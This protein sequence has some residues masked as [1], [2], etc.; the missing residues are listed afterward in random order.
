MKSIR[1]KLLVYIMLLVSTPIVIT[2]AMNIITMQKNYETELA[3]NNM[4][5]ASSIADQVSA[6]ITEA[7]SMTEQVA[8]N[9]IIN[10]TPEEQN[11]ILMNIYRKHPYFEQLYVQDIE[12][13]QTAM[14][15]GD[16][17]DV[18][19]RW[20]FIKAKEE[21]A[22]FVSKSY[23]D[24]I[25]NAPVAT[26]AIPIYD[27]DKALGVMAVDIKLDELQKRVQK[28]NEGSRYAF[29]IDGDGVV[30]A[31]PDSMQISELYNYKTLKKTLLKRD[32]KGAVIADE[33]RNHVTEE[34]DIEV[35]DELKQII[36]K[37][38]NGEEGSASYKDSKGVNVVSAY[39]SISLPGNSDNW[40]V[41]TV[42]NKVDAMAFI[43]NIFD[44]NAIIGLISIF[45]SAIF[46]RI[47]AGR[48]AD[49]IIKAAEY[50]KVIAQGNFVIDVDSKL[51]SR[52]DEIGIMTTGIQLMKESLKALTMKVSDEAVNIQ[53]KVELVLGEINELNTN[54]EGISATTEQ[55]SA[56]SEE[57]AAS[58][59]E[60]T[61]TT[62]EIERAA[63]TIAESSGKGALAA[64]DISERAEITKEKVN[65]S[66]QKTIDIF[67]ESKRHLENAIEESKVVEEINVLS[68]SIMGIAEQTNLLAINAAIEAARAGESGK[69]FAVV[70]NEITKLADQAK[71]TVKKITEVTSTVI[72]AVDN[73]SSNA[74]NLLSFVSKD[75]EDDYK[76]MLEIAEKYREDAKYVEDLVIEFSA[77]SEELLAS[78][79]NMAHSIEGVAI[80]ANESATG[81]A[82]IAASVS[83][84]NIKS[85]N[86]KD[87]IKETK[88]S[89]YNLK[90]EIAKFKF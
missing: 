75:V 63:Q 74:N 1:Q 48:I 52:K 29:V 83:E 40:A 22:S 4:M 7:Y 10:Y 85:S 20:W 49:P 32:E 87:E 33:N 88:E 70:A 80:S 77:T 73:L 67:T 26:I 90:A 28:Y 34:Q 53:N 81:T 66:I 68:A 24:L 58:T 55:L 72:G 84:A 30:I 60:M 39:K 86:V 82:E 46:I 2:T 12:G 11:E 76:D 57:T 71:A 42:E 61:A 31:H 14:T 36:E 43:Y 37:A 64:K 3:E 17:L 65:L 15:S 9:K 13:R 50:L 54:L 23:F 35:P 5:L 59:Q 62:Q 45:L 6:F 79:E 16:L 38:L 69:G 51:M 89:S 8:L 25:S 27:G 56:N 19:D 47:M 21:Q 44:L 18:S 41:I 78:I